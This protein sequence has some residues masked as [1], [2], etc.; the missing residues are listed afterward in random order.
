MKTIVRGTLILFW[1]VISITVLFNPYS[2][3]GSLFGIKESIFVVILR[4]VGCLGCLASLPFMFGREANHAFG[5]FLSA[6]C[7]AGITGLGFATVDL[8]NLFVNGV[9]FWIMGALSLA[10]MFYFLSFYPQAT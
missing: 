9:P 8:T 6:I 5:A 1:G 7:C 4:M 2:V 10:T 3:I